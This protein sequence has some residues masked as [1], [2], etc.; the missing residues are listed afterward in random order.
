MR[1]VLL[2]LFLAIGL[3]APA[4]ESRGGMNRGVPLIRNKV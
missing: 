2:A 3:A 4:L 1:R